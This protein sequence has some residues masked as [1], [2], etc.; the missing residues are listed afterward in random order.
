[1]SKLWKTF[2]PHDHARTIQLKPAEGHKRPNNQHKWWWILYTYWRTEN[3]ALAL[4][5]RLTQLTSLTTR[6][7]KHKVYHILRHQISVKCSLTRYNEENNLVLTVKTDQQTIKKKQ[8][9]Q[10]HVNDIFEGLLVTKI[11]SKASLTQESLKSE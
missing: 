11:N 6:N 4:C 7:L 9:H 5:W 3:A 8:N 1:M 2:F 10:K